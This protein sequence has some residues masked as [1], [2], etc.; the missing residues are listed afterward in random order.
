GA[1]LVELD[2][3]GVAGSLGDR[4]ADID[5]VGH[6]QIVADDL[7][8]PAERGGVCLEAF[9]V[10]LGETVLDGDDRIALEPSAV[11]VVHLRRGLLALAAAYQL[12][13]TLGVEGARC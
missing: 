1:D 4:T 2:E 12:V 5:G 10:V 3:R 9:P 13:A 7:Q 6:E 8:A 11:Q